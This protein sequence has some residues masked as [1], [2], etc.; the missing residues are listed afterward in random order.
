MT[1]SSENVWRRI[2][3]RAPG[4]SA[5]TE[6]T[7]K[8]AGTRWLIERDLPEELEVRQHLACAEHD[9][10]QRI[11]GHGHGKAGFF[12]QPLVEIL[13]ERPAAGKHD[14]AIDDVGR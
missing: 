12:T 7:P 11:L 1:I 3:R 9:G 4:G 10:R 2:T 14:A 8:P 5:Q 6:N 13:Q